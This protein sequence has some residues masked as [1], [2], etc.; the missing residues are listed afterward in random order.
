M[1]YARRAP[2]ICFIRSEGNISEVYSN[3]VKSGQASLMMHNAQIP[4]FRSPPTSVASCTDE[5]VVSLSCSLDFV[6][7][8]FIFFRVGMSRVQDVGLSLQ[9][10]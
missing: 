7:L 2:S 5:D 8:V 10:G 6:L 9:S 1:R 4:P 3:G